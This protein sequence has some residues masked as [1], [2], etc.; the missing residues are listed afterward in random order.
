VLAEMVNLAWSKRRKSKLLVV[1]VIELWT[2]LHQVL[3]VDKEELDN[4]VL[5]GRLAAFD[6]IPDVYAVGFVLVPV[7]FCER[8]KMMGLQPAIAEHKGL[9]TAFP[10]E[11]GVN[12][13]LPVRHEV[14]V[15]A[16]RTFHS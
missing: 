14:G 9:G 4:I 7:V 12:R 11:V 1:C 8:C 15:V 6:D 13:E 10:V 2:D 16:T 5:V 3:H